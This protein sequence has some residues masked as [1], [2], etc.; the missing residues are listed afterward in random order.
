MTKE[1][2]A[3]LSEEELIDR[4]T[5]YFIRKD[6]EPERARELAENFL[7][8]LFRYRRMTSMLEGALVERLE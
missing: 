6:V 8:T 5:T 7:E 4:V 3:L 1:E 2:I